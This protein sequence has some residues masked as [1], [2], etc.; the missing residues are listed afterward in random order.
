MSQLSCRQSLRDIESNHESQ[1]EKLYHLGAKRIARSTL[2]RINE[3]QPASLYQ[4]LFIHWSVKPRG[5]ARG[6]KRV[7]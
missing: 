7:A 1:Q 6:Y 4:Q 5:L 2:A 3:E